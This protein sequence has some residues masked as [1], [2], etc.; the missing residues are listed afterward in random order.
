[1]AAKKSQRSQQ[2]PFWD[3]ATE[4]IEEEYE[5]FVNWAASRT[6]NRQ[7][8]KDI[9]QRV[10]VNVLKMPDRSK[11]LL[12][13]PRKYLFQ[14]IQNEACKFFRENKRRRIDTNVRVEGIDRPALE[15]LPDDPMIERLHKA[16]DQ[17]DM[18]ACE[19]L[20]LRY[21]DEMTEQQIADTTGK[22]RQ[23]VSMM[24]GRRRDDIEVLMTNPNAKRGRGRPSKI[25]EALKKAGEKITEILTED[26]L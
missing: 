1:M 14:A 17:L 18:E 15:P 10:L 25:I 4:L 16:M 22:T 20:M 6:K 5:V 8:G 21:C 12:E 11:E 9:V 7:D 24:L 2:R 19:L 26:G 13:D 23:A 3:V